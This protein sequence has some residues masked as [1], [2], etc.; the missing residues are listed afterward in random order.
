M[1]LVKNKLLKRIIDLLCSKELPCYI[2]GGYV[3]EWLLGQQGKDVDFVVAGA[4]IPLARQVANETA[5]AFYVLD[6]GMDAARIVYP[7]PL[8]LVVD[9]AAMRGADIVADL[10]A[11]DFTINAMAVD[12]REC[13]AHRPQIIDPCGGQRDLAARV[14]RATNE[15][16][17]QQDAVRL[18]RAVRF[19]ATL[20]LSV[21]PQT[22]LWMRRDAA[23]ITQPAAERIRQELALI[24][25]A[26]G[27]AGHLRY[28]DDLGLM[29]GVIPEVS[30]L[31]GIQHPDLLGDAYEHTLAT[32]AEVERL[33]AFAESQLGPEEA[34]FLG[35]FAADLLTYFNEIIC[36]KRTRYTLLKFSAML[37]DV[38]Q[39]KNRDMKG[40]T[41]AEIAAR[42]LAR[43]HFSAREVRLVSAVVARYMAVKALIRSMPLTGRAIYRFFRDSD[44]AGVD[45]LVLS[46]AD[47]LAMGVSAESQR[48]LLELINVMLDHYFRRPHEAV[49]PPSLVTGNDVMTL[50]DLRP[51]PRVGQLLEAV[52]EAQAEGQV[53]TRQEALDFLRECSI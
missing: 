44:G 37:H 3:R 19:V 33:M 5:G 1:H 38:G 20:G 29:H 31:R 8:D 17:F 52:R 25:A 45:A 16:V 26:P 7:A 36:E 49:A 50:L 42:V 24:V 40:P 12:V 39:W 47:H 4:A 28:M 27:A 48:Q 21:E 53:R 2:A 23:L 32:V 9:F 6:E 10:C 30:A 11:R 51:G 43:L 22:E 34:Q 14:L 15:R 41:S 13:Y 35:P 46:L 18:L